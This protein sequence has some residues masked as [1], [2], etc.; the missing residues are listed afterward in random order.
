MHATP[1][2]PPLHPPPIPHTHLPLLLLCW[3]AAKEKLIHVLSFYRNVL[4]DIPSTIVQLVTILP[5]AL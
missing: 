4:S 2:P 3:T 1:T 5:T